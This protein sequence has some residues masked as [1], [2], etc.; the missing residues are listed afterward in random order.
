ME[1]IVIA[2]DSTLENVRLNF[3]H[4]LPKSEEIEEKRGSF[5]PLETLSG[6]VPENFFPAALTSMSAAEALKTLTGND[7]LELF[8]TLLLSN[9]SEY[10]L[11][12]KLKSASSSISKENYLNL[13]IFLLIKTGFANDEL[14][15]EIKKHLTESDPVTD[16]ILSFYDKAPHEITD[17]SSMESLCASFFEAVKAE[18]SGDYGKAFSM[19]LKVFEESDLHPFIFEILKF[20]IMQHSGISPENIAEF[21]KKATES[22]LAVSF[23][24]VKFVEFCYY[25]K[26]NIEEKIEET[27]SVLAENTDSVFIL[28]IIAPFFTNTKSGISSENST[29]SLPK[30]RSV[31]KRRCISS[32]SQTS[33]STNWNY[34]ILLLKYT[35][36]SL[37]RIL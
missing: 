36:T 2:N 7:E 31:L 19:M 28:N 21:T 37:K 18:K 16:L 9:P 3:R 12:E 15:D 13:L 25:Y 35:E 14:I 32:F 5:K 11:F 17:T 4:I 26:N 10:G 20:Y 6:K 27:V 1:K 29:N 33:M 34:L 8:F 24:T 23:T 22:S 30:K